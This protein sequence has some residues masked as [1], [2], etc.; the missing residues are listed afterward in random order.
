M[1]SGD[2]GK[3]WALLNQGLPSRA[4]TA[5]VAD[6]ND[7][8][9][10]Y[11]ATEDW[12]GVL[13][14]TDGGASWDFYD[15]QG[16]IYG[17]N[18]TGLAYSRAEGGRLIA[19]TRDGRILTHDSSGG[20][21]ELRMGISKGAIS[22]LAVAGRDDEHV[23]AGTS[24]GIVI[25]SL[26]GGRTW[27]VLG[28]IPAQFQILGISTAPDNPERLFASAYGNG[29]HRLWESRDGGQTWKSVQ[30]LG[31]PRTS[32]GSPIILGQEPYQMFVGGADG[33]F[34]SDNMGQTWNKEPL[35]APLAS[36]KTVALSARRSK[37]VYVATGGS[38]FVND[39]SIYTQRQAENH[40]WQYGQGLEAELV[41]TVVVDP[42]DSRLAY[43]GVLLLG[44]WSVFRTQDGGQSW[45]RTE[46]PKIEPVVPDTIA[47]AVGLT[48][49]GGSVVYAGTVGCGVFR[50]TDQGQSWE[51]YGRARCDQIT[52]M[53]SDAFFL[54]VDAKDADHV[55][56]AAGQEFFSSKDGGY[57]WKRHELPI[58]SPIMGLA[59]DALQS[60]VIYLVAGASG[61]WSSKDAGETW[62]Q[63][64][65]LVFEGVELSSVAAVPGKT[66]HLVIGASNGAIW[67]TSDG[68]QTWRSIREKLA[69]GPVTS[70]AV[71]ED[72]NGRILIGSADDGMALFI[73]GRIFGG[74]Q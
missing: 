4:V 11:A 54:A 33:L 13:R 66:E 6:P 36:I 21:W 12:R 57:R 34:V 49:A 70:I 23:Y 16:E 51:T 73:P 2:G 48:K 20:E 43:A 53:P 55:Y 61:F 59:S 64:R 3:T 15:D 10:V 38:V 60:D 32:I 42:N 7:P 1:R 52:T 46:A 37:P 58:K 40:D 65:S 22:A 25:R 8:S 68:G 17:A 50:T 28:Q 44:E 72:L 5:L 19:G 18:M 30:G 31:L 24:R 26:D 74:D 62:H 14:S 35:E 29:G 56:S 9:T 27:E 71:S 39:G 67:T 45:Q 69:I 41:R 63:Q 47:L